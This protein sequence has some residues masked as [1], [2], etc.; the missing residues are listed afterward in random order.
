MRRWGKALLLLAVLLGAATALYRYLS[1]E[2][3]EKVTVISPT[4]RNVEET[5]SATGSVQVNRTVLVTIEPGAKIMAL[6][7]QEKDHV[8]KGQLLATL[9]EADLKSQLSQSEANLELAQA[10]LAN[11]RVNLDRVRR[12]REKGFAALQEVEAAERQIDL[13]R[14]HVEERKA[15]IDLIKTKQARTAILA[16]VSGV[17]TRKLAEEGG[18]VGNSRETLSG[19]EL[20][21]AEIGEFPFEF[22][23][24]VDQADISKV[25]AGR[26]ATVSFDAFP[27]RVFAATTEAIGLD[28][29]PDTTGRVRYRVTLKFGQPSS[30]LKLGMTGTVHFV[31][32]AKPQALTLPA[33]VILQQGDDEFIF[34]LEGHKA[35]IRKIKT[36]IRGEDVVEVISGLTSGEQVIDQGRA[37]LRDGQGVEVLNAKR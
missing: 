22:H 14:T 28:S 3:P 35:R 8:K 32:A 37:K 20:P 25:R 29:T 15:A 36:G 18:V 10:N 24:E 11:A 5:V 21:I 6:H 30:N 7:F 33:S 34:V 26:R 27:D 23:A 19:R 4:L 31:L 2:E 1:R 12:L 13:Y 17:V 16:P 9:D